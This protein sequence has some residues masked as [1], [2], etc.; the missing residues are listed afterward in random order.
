MSGNKLDEKASM[1][2]EVEAENISLS[3]LP[4]SVVDVETSPLDMVGLE[5]A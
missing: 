5:L 1:I 2:D 4:N 3:P